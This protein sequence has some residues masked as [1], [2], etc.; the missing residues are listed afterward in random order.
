[1]NLDPSSFLTSLVIS[2]IGFV[3]LSYGRKMSRPPHMIA[4]ILLLVFP[5]FIEN[6]LIMC[7]IAALILLVLWLAARFGW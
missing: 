4:G 7:A 3:L 6:V 1:M 2:S 5:Y